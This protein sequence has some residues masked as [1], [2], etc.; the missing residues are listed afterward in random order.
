MV[1]IK[2][3]QPLCS[4]AGTHFTEGCCSVNPSSQTLTASAEVIY[5]C[6]FWHVPCLDKRVYISSSQTSMGYAE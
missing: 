6:V 4:S 5:P 2:L 1:K 3:S